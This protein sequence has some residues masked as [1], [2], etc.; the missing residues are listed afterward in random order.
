MIQSPNI[1]NPIFSY[2]FVVFLILLG[3]GR[4]EPNPDQKLQLRVDRRLTEISGYAGVLFTMMH[5][6]KDLYCLAADKISLKNFENDPTDSP[7]ERKVNDLLHNLV[8]RFSRICQFYGEAISE[9]TPVFEEIKQRGSLPTKLYYFSIYLPDD[10]DN[11]STKKE[12]DIGLFSSLAK[13]ETIE[14]IARENNIPTRKCNQW[15]KT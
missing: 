2:L 4:E 7:E 10:N 11:G 14:M 9:T 5:L 3:C 8:N 6:K 13:C 15:N 1:R 12:E